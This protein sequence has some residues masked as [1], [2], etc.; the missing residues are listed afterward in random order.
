[1][2]LFLSTDPNARLSHGGID[3]GPVGAAPRAAQAVSQATVVPVIPSASAPAITAEEQV[4]AT[5]FAV[6][7]PNLGTFY[8][9][10][11]PGAAPYVELGQQ[12][13]ADTEIC[14]LEVMKLFTAVRAELPGIVRRVCVEDGHMVE[15]GQVLFYIERI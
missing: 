6:T 15:H 5:W 12:V 10:P 4:P 2:Q 9:A 3:H 11:K 7:A 14:L 8:R 13:A 1:L